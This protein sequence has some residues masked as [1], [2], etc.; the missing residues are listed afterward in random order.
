MELPEIIVTAEDAASVHAIC[1]R[2][3]GYSLGAHYGFFKWSITAHPDLRDILILGV[4]HGRD[5]AFML[6]II[7]RYCPDRAITIT[8]VDK[9]SDTPCADWPAD[10]RA[11]SW[12]DAGFGAPPTR[13]A[14]IAN[15]RLCAP[16]A[17]SVDLIECPH[18][19]YVSGASHVFDLIYQ[20]GSHDYPSVSAQ[21]RAIPRLCRSPSTLVCGDD[22]SDDGTWGVKRAVTES[23]KESLLFENWIWCGRMGDMRIAAQTPLGA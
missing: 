6:D 13:A 22:Y 7:A 19:E 20:D 5:I 9:F 21:H 16:S 23:F 8:G 18:E 10:R 15:L 11:L 4:Y 14:A 17:A 1:Q 2:I 12:Q 3:P